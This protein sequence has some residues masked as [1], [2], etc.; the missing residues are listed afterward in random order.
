MKNRW[1]LISFSALSSLLFICGNVAFAEDLS[2]RQIVD[3]SL[4]NNAF[5]FNNA[6][7]QIELS[8]FSKRGSK[9]IR[10]IRIKSQEENELTKTLV[11]FIHCRHR[12]LCCNT[13]IH[14]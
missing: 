4:K 8:I 7:A 5:G 13:C 6:E 11:R 1:L 3:R 12:F 10:S 2:A 14:F 9:R